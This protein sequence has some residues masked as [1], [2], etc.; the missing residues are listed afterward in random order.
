MSPLSVKQ[1]PRHHHNEELILETAKERDRAMKKELKKIR[2]GEK[3]L[4]KGERQRKGL[5][6]KER[7]RQ[8]EICR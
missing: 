3:E 5:R 7:E 6:G 1:K 2:D 4:E 8:I